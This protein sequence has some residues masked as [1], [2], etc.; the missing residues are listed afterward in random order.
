MKAGRIAHHYPIN[1][2]GT[3]VA[4]LAVLL[5]LVA[6]QSSTPKGAIE[7]MP[8]PDIYADGTVDHLIPEKD[9]FL[10]LPYNGILYATDRAP[11]DAQAIAAGKPAYSNQRGYVLRMGV[12]DVN[13][14]AAEINWEE[15]RRISL[16]KNRDSSYPIAVRE[17][18]EYGV[19]AT[20]VTPL[21][22]ESFPGVAEAA[23]QQRFADAINEQLSKS[24]IPDVFVYVHGYK[25]D[26]NNP[27]LVATELWHFLGYSGA[28]VAYSWPSTPK[29]TAY[30]RDIDTAAGFARNFRLFL[31]FLAEQT[32]A[33]RIHVIGYSAGTRLV[34]RGFEQMAIAS[35]Y[36]PADKAWEKYRIGNL[37]L[38]AS[39]IDRS[40]FGEYLAD[41]LLRVPQQTSVYM[42]DSDKAL[43]VSRFLTDRP[44]LG[45]LWDSGAM[46]DDTQRYLEQE[47]RLTLINVN[48]AEGAHS[49]NGH[50][51]FRSSPWVSSD[52]LIQMAFDLPP[53][54]RGLVRQPDSP[55]WTFPPDY[56]A[57]LRELLQSP[58]P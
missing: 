55:L 42:S 31:E 52:V 38:V 9:P 29:T 53:I 12:G 18:E 54:E 41:G 26:F 22:D 30:V 3:Q 15:A 37:I 57:R 35:Q 44:R 56:A 8:A 1:G 7:L 34:A 47:P 46:P 50:A 36:L 24:N 32:N 17:V 20:S 45:Q 6:C 19:L 14:A 16:L 5:S 48:D 21:L 39:D 13:A 28:F 25:V 4:L 43:G 58:A 23:G 2:R 40:V 27:L 49:G 10:S 33:R 51:Y 11:N